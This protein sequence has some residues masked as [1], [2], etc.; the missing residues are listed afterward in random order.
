MGLGLG[1]G[2]NRKR[3]EMR[4]SFIRTRRLWVVLLRS[5]SLGEK[6]PPS[7]L[8]AEIR[9]S[10]RETLTERRRE[11][12]VVLHNISPGGLFPRVKPDPLVVDK[13]GRGRGWVKR[14]KAAFFSLKSG[15]RVKL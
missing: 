3:Y 11:R 8:Q 1:G 13:T 2:N 5:P 4:G 14:R 9:D 12:G 7:R 15:N 10:G 6:V